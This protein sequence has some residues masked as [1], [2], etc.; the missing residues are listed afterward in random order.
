MGAAD[1]AKF[2]SEE[3]IERMA[4]HAQDGL[5][6]RLMNDPEYSQAAYDADTVALNARIQAMHESRAR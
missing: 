3:Q 4:E 6:W 2:Y 1:M 5:D